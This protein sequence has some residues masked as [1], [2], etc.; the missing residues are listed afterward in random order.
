[1][2]SEVVRKG[3]QNRAVLMKMI[4]YNRIRQCDN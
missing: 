3:K 1:M 2:R 4:S